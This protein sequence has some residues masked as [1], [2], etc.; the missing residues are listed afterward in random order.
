ML[1]DSQSGYWG[2]LALKRREVDAVLPFLSA[3]INALW[4]HPNALLISSDGGVFSMLF[5]QDAMLGQIMLNCLWLL[6]F[7]LKHQYRPYIPHIESV[8]E[9]KNSWGLMQVVFLNALTFYHFMLLESYEWLV[10]ITEFHLAI[11][12][13]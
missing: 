12:F 2:S 11:G 10:P 13:V 7:K 8:N 5:S 1:V 3:V 4:F 9:F 6:W